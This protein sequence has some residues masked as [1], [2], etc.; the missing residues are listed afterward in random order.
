MRTRIMLAAMASAFALATVLIAQTA[1]PNSQSQ[2]PQTQ[3]PPP[4]SGQTGSSQPPS[5]TSPSSQSGSTQGQT[6]AAGATTQHSDPVADELGL[7]PDQ[8][9][10]LQPIIDDEVNQINAVRNDSSMTTEQKQQKVQ[11]IREA[12]FPKIQAILTPEQRQKLQQMQADHARQQQQQQGA[13]SG[14]TTPPPQ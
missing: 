9:T 7:T 8:R 14:S 11:Q 3:A 5:A 12:G 13:P 2:T 10:R 4:S 6:G 1:T